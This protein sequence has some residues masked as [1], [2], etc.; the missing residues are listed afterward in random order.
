M[1]G[2]LFLGSFLP[3]LAGTGEEYTTSQSPSIGLNDAQTYID[4]MHVSRD[5]TTRIFS[6]AAARDQEED[7]AKRKAAEAT[8]NASQGGDASQGTRPMSQSE[9]SRGSSR[10]GAAAAVDDGKDVE[11]P[12]QGD[13]HVGL[14]NET[15]IDVSIGPVSH[16]YAYFALGRDTSTYLRS[17]L[18]VFLCCPQVKAK[19]AR[20]RA[21][22]ADPR[23]YDRLV[24]SMAPNVW[25][26]EDVKKGLMCQLFGGSCKI[27]PGGRIRGEINLLL[28]S[29][30]DNISRDKI[31]SP[32]MVI[33]NRP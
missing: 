8:E 26:M 19:E 1:K 31:S 23:I 10:A 4:V 5:E 29:E 24:A 14:G 30:G 9:M 7:E 12:V 6:L 27:F 28:V 25:E 20:I 17:S 32:S 18:V 21:L 13:K 11:D 22:A 15:H 3:R 16:V 33:D 2:G